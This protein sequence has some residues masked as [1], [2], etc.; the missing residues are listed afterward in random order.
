[1]DLTFHLSGPTGV[2][3]AAEI[4]VSPSQLDAMISSLIDLAI[5]MVQARCTLQGDPIDDVNAPDRVRHL[6]RFLQDDL[7]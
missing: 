4:T 3:D 6:R 2:F 1:M 5:E 7:T